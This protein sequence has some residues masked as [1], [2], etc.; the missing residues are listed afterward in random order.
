MVILNKYKPTPTVLYIHTSTWMCLYV[1]I[2]IYIYFP[3]CVWCCWA[4]SNIC[5][6]EHQH[7]NDAITSQMAD[8]LLN[9]PSSPT[10]CS[11]CWCGSLFLV[12]MLLLLPVPLRTSLLLYFTTSRC[13]IYGFKKERIDVECSIKWNIKKESK[14][15]RMYKTTQFIFI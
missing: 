6:A 3:V 13:A 11:Y 8:P 15:K 9:Q 10:S 4:R 2:Y 14:K 12:D 5:I 7:P 1:S